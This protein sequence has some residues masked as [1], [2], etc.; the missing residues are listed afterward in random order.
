MRV[1]PTYRNVH[2]DTICQY[3][4]KQF[5]TLPLFTGDNEGDYTLVDSLSSKYSC[6]SVEILQLRVNPVYFIPETFEICENGSYNWHGREFSG[7]TSGSYE[8]WDS[9]K[10]KAGCDSIYKLSLRVIETYEFPTVRTMCEND[11]VHWRSHYYFGDKFSIGG[12]APGVYTYTDSF[13]T[14][15]LCDSVYK[16]TLYVNRVDFTDLGIDSAC[17]GDV[18]PLCT[19]KYLCDYPGTYDFRDTLKNMYGC[20]S[21]VKVTVK[22]YPTYCFETQ[23][24]ICENGTYQWRGHSFSNLTV[25]T[26]VTED[27]YVSSHGCD[28]IY[29]LTLTVISTYFYQT[30]YSM[31]DYDT[32]TWRGIKIGPLHADSYV[33]WDSLKTQAGC[34][35]V[36]KLNLVVH[37]S[38]YVHES[39][40]MCDNETIPYLTHTLIYPP[41]KYI[42]IDTL[43]SHYGCDSIVEMTVYVHPTYYFEENETIC[44][45]E[46]YTWH[47]QTYR[48]SGTYYDRQ[49]T[50]TW[51][52]DSIY[53]LN[54]YVQP[55]YKFESYRT[56]CDNE[57]IE[58]QG[59]TLRDPGSHT[60]HYVTVNGCDSDYVIYL[61]V[62]KSSFENRYV[63]ICDYETYSFAGKTLNKTGVYHDSLRTSKGCDSVITL[64]LTVN[65]S[66]RFVT[67]R[68][69]MCNDT[70]MFRG[71]SYSKA[72]TYYDSLKTQGG[73]DSVYV[74]VRTDLPSYVFET[75]TTLC[76]CYQLKWRGKTYLQSGTFYDSLKTRAGCDSIYVLNLKYEPTSFDSIYKEICFGESYT[77][78]GNSYSV[79]GVYYDTLSAIKNF[80]CN[81]T[82]LTLSVIMPT[83]FIKMSVPDICADDSLFIIDH[84]YKGEKPITY[85]VYFDDAAINEGFQNQINKPYDGKIEALVPKFDRQDKYVR[86]DYYGVTVSLDNGVCDPEGYQK[87]EKMLVRWPSWITE[88]RWQDVVAVVNDK[89]NGGYTFSRFD[90][91]VNSQY[92]PNDRE[93]YIY[94]YEKLFIGDEV[95]VKLTRDGESYSIPSCPIII[96]DR[97][98]MQGHDL[99]IIVQLPGDMSSNIAKVKSEVDA[100]YSVSDFT[101]K[102]LENGEIIRN[103]ETIIE[104]PYVAG[105]YLVR[106]YSKDGRNKV[107]KVIIK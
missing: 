15:S 53:Q 42:L 6:D 88:Q 83:E 60:F 66:Y 94:M 38:F 46:T 58:F 3:E 18:Y 1:N 16:L 11:S 63:T 92:M 39:M 67:Y 47:G 85:S 44:S 74:L 96:E 91:Y 73:C 55:A 54:L 70:V 87:E 62:N 104:F 10:T 107:M 84:A 5:S 72:G 79:S 71:K 95:Y 61:T 56:I 17:K 102:I 93:S 69:N 68:E 106:F 7:L 98:A 75:D 86:P 41:G 97:R 90:W 23:A 59:V 50:Q 65:P 35:S 43:D 77:V 25:G 8:Y 9:L 101:G 99:P 37:P 14:K 34:D 19:K 105:V 40:D 21:V 2:F 22:V 57:S 48:V 31:C 24:S 20:D 33:F 36:Y 52:C 27:K 26:H 64:H 12:L 13:K 81:V 100:Y 82:K 76:D 32:M 51:N 45:N 80:D 28:S 29:K 103:V 49:K 4:T 30:P 89:Y 78:H